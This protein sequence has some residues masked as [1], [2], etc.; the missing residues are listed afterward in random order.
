MCREP[1][2]YQHQSKIT[3]TD[4]GNAFFFGELGQL[5]QLGVGGVF[6]NAHHVQAVVGCK[7]AP[8]GMGHDESLARD[9]I[10]LHDALDILVQ[11]IQLRQKRVQIGLVVGLSCAG[12]I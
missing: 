4:S 10:R 8:G 9:V 3:T 2:L 12:S 7:I 11:R 5:H 6:G 1:L